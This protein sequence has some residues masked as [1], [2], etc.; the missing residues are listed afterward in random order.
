VAAGEGY[1]VRYFARKHGISQDQ[2]RA[3]IKKVGND[4]AKLNEAAQ[5]LK[6]A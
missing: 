3:L 2:A 4:R 5:A 6:S 1:E